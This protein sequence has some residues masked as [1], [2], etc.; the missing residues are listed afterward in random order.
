MRRFASVLAALAL[1]ATLVLW[2]PAPAEAGVLSKAGGVLGGVGG[3]IL[4]VGK[5]VLCKGLSATGTVAQGATTVGGAAV[6]G[7]STEGAGAAEGAAAGSAVGGVLKKGVGAV[8]NA[9]CSSSG[10]AASTIA[11]AAVGA[12]AAAATFDLAA[13]WMI[14]AAEKITGAI[15]SMITTSSSPQLTACVVSAVVRADGRARRGA[16]AARD[17]DR[18]DFGGCATRPGGARGDAAGIVRAGLGTGLLIAPNDARSADLGRD[19]RGRDPRARIR[20][21]GRRSG[22]R[23]D[24]AGSVGSGPRR[25]RC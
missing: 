19:L 14:D 10:S 2:S 11:K 9:I 6:G 21:S 23:G 3:T 13:R 22:A 24:R 16:R 8:T 15:V 7:A 4:G 5:S 12:V 1:A 20:R 17:A 25:W 18:A